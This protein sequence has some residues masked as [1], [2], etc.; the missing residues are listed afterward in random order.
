MIENFKRLI[1]IHLP[2]D[3]ISVFLSR[4]VFIEVS[5]HYL[6]KLRFRSNSPSVMSGKMR[7]STHD[8]QEGQTATS[9][10]ID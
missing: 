10:K 6:L 1:Q 4:K 3:R 7:S 8:A 2:T 5:G 9:G